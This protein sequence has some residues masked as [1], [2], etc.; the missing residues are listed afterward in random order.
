MTD[1]TENDAGHRPLPRPTRMDELEEDDLDAEAEAIVWGDATL[2]ESIDLYTDGQR[3]KKHCED[4][5]AGATAR[6][7]AIVVGADGQAAGLKPFD[8]G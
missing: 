1:L 6:I 8:A 7:E 3:L 2:E 5:L 4:K